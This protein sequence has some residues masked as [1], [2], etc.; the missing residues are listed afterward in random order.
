MIRSAAQRQRQTGA[1][2][3]GQHDVEERRILGSE[4]AGH[5]VLV[6]IIEGEHCL[7]AGEAVVAGGK[8]GRR[9]AQLQRFG[10]VLAVIDGE[11]R[12][13]GEVKG[14]V[15]GARL[16]L[17]A[18]GGHDDDVEVGLKRKGRDSV[19]HHRVALLEDELDVELV[20]G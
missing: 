15:E 3:E 13:A 1:G 12:P 14:I 4:L 7:Q 19:T 9:P 20:A 2:K 18:S 6:G 17:R 10:D 8:D 16:G 5:P 11:Q